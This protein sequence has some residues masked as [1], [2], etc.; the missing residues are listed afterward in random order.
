MNDLLQR[1]DPAAGAVIDSESLRSRV[2]ERLG[3]AGTVLPVAVRV[4]RPWLAAAAAFAVYEIASHGDWFGS[5]VLGTVALTALAVGA[6]ACG[7]NAADDAS[8]LQLPG[9]GH[10]A[11]DEERHAH[12]SVGRA[13]EVPPSVVG[14]AEAHALGQVRLRKANRGRGVFLS[15]MRFS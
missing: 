2:D 5:F 8:V 3:L 7:T 13:D 4:R 9:S 15:F 14:I 12:E 11:V 6:T 1:F 10:E